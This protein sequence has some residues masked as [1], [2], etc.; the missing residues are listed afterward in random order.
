MECEKC[1]RTTPLN[2]IHCWRLDTSSKCK[3]QNVLHLH[4]QYHKTIYLCDSCLDTVRYCCGDNLQLVDETREKFLSIEYSISKIR[5][6]ENC[7]YVICILIYGCQVL[8]QG[9]NM[10]RVKFL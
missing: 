10:E 6:T 3:P 8:N 9:N 1:I 2:T 5:P 7:D 4:E